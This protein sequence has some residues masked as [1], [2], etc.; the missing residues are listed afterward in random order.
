L[1]CKDKKTQG[2]RALNPIPHQSR[3]GNSSNIYEIPSN[4]AASMAGPTLLALSIDFDAGGLQRYGGTQIL[5]FGVSSQIPLMWLHRSRW[6]GIC[7]FI[8]FLFNKSDKCWRPPW[9]L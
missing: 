7:L 9:K 5:S 3:L 2:K 4:V 1:R 6:S 8:G